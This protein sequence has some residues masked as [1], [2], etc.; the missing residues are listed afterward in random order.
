MK[1]TNYIC[2]TIDKV[3]YSNDIQQYLTAKVIEG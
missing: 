3:K 2:R 1:E